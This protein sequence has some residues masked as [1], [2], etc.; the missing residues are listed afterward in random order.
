MIVSI[1]IQ[2]HSYLTDEPQTLNFGGKYIYEF[3][4]INKNHLK[5]HRRHNLKF[6]ANFFDVSKSKCKISLLSA[7]VGE[8][9]AGKSSILNVIRSS[10]IKHPY[11][12]PSSVATILVEVD[13]EMD[14]Q[15]KIPV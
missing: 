14:M 12:M 3:R 13:S 1:Y 10:F 2:E 5:I 7:I 4:E 8:N 11:S 15:T 6:V 9:G